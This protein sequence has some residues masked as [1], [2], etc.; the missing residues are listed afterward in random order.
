MVRGIQHR[1][2]HGFSFWLLQ[3]IKSDYQ[4]RALLSEAGIDYMCNCPR[5]MHYHKCKH[6]L[7][8][9]VGLNDKKV[10]TKFSQKV[11]GKRKAPAGATLSKRG[12]CLHID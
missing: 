11:C 8:I 5:F 7:A 3:P 9:N 12:H 10:P 2:W 1:K 6:V 4:Q